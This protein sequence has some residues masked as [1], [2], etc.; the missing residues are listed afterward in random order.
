MP[1]SVR[2]SN[3]LQ[4]EAAGE[5]KLSPTSL[6]KLHIQRYTFNEHDS[7]YVTNDQFF[8]EPHARKNISYVEEPSSRVIIQ[9]S[10]SFSVRILIRF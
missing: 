3:H 5:V 8:N 1:L 6:P 7:E 10:G 2:C 4:L 9:I